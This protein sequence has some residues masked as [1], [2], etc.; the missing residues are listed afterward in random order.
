MPETVLFR[1]RFLFFR[2]NSKYTLFECMLSFKLQG[3][4]SIV[5]SWRSTMLQLNNL[6]D[7]LRVMEMRPCR[8]IEMSRMPVSAPIVTTLTMAATLMNM[9]VPLLW[10]LKPLLLPYSSFIF[11]TCASCHANHSILFALS[12]EQVNHS[13]SVLFK[14]CSFP[15]TPK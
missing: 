4:L 10:C 2:D 3:V 11:N 13:A 8:T 14:C 12:V 5:L 7:T 1:N 15:S 6:R 9:I